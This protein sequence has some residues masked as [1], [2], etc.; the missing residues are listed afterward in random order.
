MKTRLPSFSRVPQLGRFLLALLIPLSLGCT[1]ASP[2]VN[3]DI[4]E[5]VSQ[6]HA[7]GQPITSIL[8]VAMREGTSVAAQ[9]TDLDNSSAPPIEL[10]VPA[11]DVLFELT[12]YSTL[13]SGELTPTYFGDRKVSI[14]PFEENLLQLALFPA[15]TL[16]VEVDL[17]GTD[18]EL[19]DTVVRFIPINLKPGQSEYYESSFTR[20][21]LTRILPAGRYKVRAEASFAGREF[22]E[23]S[24]D[25]LV[26]LSQGQTNKLIVEVNM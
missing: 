26:E 2:K 14:E 3:I 25:V 9:Q 22:R 16:D 18:E 5:L 4:Q 17:S 24:D 1:S 8:T 19:P 21:T 10:E 13:D 15:G 11:G 7:L 6:S 20:G 23:L 12:G